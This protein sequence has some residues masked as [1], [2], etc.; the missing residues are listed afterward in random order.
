MRPRLEPLGSPDLYL[1]ASAF[2]LGAQLV[3]LA[4]AGAAHHADRRRRQGMMRDAARVM[5]AL[6]DELAELPERIFLAPAAP[7]PDLERCD[8]VHP[9][10]G[11]QC[12]RP[13]G[14][15][16]KHGRERTIDGAP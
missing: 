5:G 8:F 7:E 1:W 10:N 11:M 6:E 9:H 4:K 2:L 12:E 14:H 16:G 3:L 15:P 13:A